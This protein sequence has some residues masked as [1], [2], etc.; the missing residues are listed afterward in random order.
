MTYLEL[1]P[2]YSLAHLLFEFFCDTLVSVFNDLEFGI[3][4]ALLEFDK[5]SNAEVTI[6]FVVLVDIEVVNHIFELTVNEL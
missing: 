6:L 4:K 2:L 3:E 1:E 5:V